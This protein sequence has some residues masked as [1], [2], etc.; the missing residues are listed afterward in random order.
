MIV[1]NSE[2]LI[3]NSYDECILK[4]RTMVIRTLEEAVHSVEPQKLIANHVRLNGN[5]LYINNDNFNLDLFDRVYVIG[6]GKASGGM[7]ES[8]EAIMKSKITA[9]IINIPKELLGQYK[10]DIISLHPA[11]HPLPSADGMEG[12]EKMINLV[13]ISEKTLVL[14]L[15]SGGGSALMPLPKAGIT[16]DEKVETTDALL[17]VG[18]DIYELNTVRKHLS[19]IK[20][21]QLAEKLYPSTVIGLIIS[22]VIGDDLDTIASG[23]LTPDKTTYSEVYRILEKYKLLHKLSPNVLS[24]IRNGIVGSISETPKPG[25]KIFDRVHQY[26]IGNNQTAIRAA[27]NYLKS[28]KIKLHAEAELSGNARS[29]GLKLGYQANLMAKL[30]EKD[31]IPR[32]IIAGGETTVKVTGSGKGGRNQHAAAAASL[33]LN[34]KGVALA[35]MGTDGIDGPTDAAGAMADR[36]T[37]IRAG[38]SAAIL[39]YLNNDNT[40]ALFKEL[41]DLIMTG[42]TGTNV[43]DVFIAVSF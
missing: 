4:A 1:H 29:A 16:L 32:Y 28:N 9:G 42:Y 33:K 14:C 35:F 6:A 23:P 15:I 2:Q 38:G 25:C 37:V 22:D 36:S 39:K 5:L 18:A 40:Y 20:G 43:N 3:K 17:K 31:G 7:A 30:T 21:G 13:K 8:V 26:I 34:R 10:T 24:L 41:N 12:T 11:T 19:G 27:K